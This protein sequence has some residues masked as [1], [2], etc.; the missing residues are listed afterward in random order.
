M[1][2]AA[3]KAASLWRTGGRYLAAPSRFGLGDTLSVQSQKR[4]TS[5]LRIGAVTVTTTDLR[6][7]AVSGT[8]S[9][10]NVTSCYSMKLAAH[11][12]EPT[13]GGK[14]Q[15]LTTVSRGSMNHPHGNSFGEVGSPASTAFV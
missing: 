2:K 12:T 1:R 7:V 15:G 8:D 5:R 9:R 10:T 4:G 13:E 11:S 14:Q 6:C 3:C